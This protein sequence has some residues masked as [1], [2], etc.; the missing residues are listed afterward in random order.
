MI[1]KN[2]TEL[3]GKTPLMELCNFEKEHNLNAKI[4]MQGMHSYNVK[5]IR[6]TFPSSTVLKYDTKN[7]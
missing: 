1:Y 5:D 7:R 2:V 6:A 4:L 3:I